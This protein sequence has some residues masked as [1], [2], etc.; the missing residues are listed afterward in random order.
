M[1]TLILTAWLALVA[2]ARAAEPLLTLTFDPVEN[3]ALVYTRSAALSGFFSPLNRL[4]FRVLV[5]NDDSVTLTI[6]G[7]RVAM[8]GLDTTIA[9][10]I[11]VAPNATKVVELATE[12]IFTLAE[13][14]PA[15]VTIGIYVA[16]NVTPKAAVLPLARYTPTVP[17][18]TYRLPVREGDLGPEQY[19]S[20][21]THMAPHVQRWGA[22][23]SVY[24]IDDDDSHTSLHPDTDGTE[25]AHSLG[26]GMPIR[27]MADGV[28]LRV[29]DG[30]IENPRPGKR[31]FQRL[32]EQD[33]A[34]IADAKV[35][36]LGKLGIPTQE[37]RTAVVTRTANGPFTITIWDS[38]SSGKTLLQRGS[39]TSAFDV[40]DIAVEALSVTR[41]VVAARLAGN[42]GTRILL[43]DVQED[44]A[45]QPVFVDDYDLPSNDV[46][47]SLARLSASRF[48]QSVRTA[49]GDLRVRVFRVVGD[50]I[51]YKSG[52]LAGAASSICT[53]PLWTSETSDEV[54]GGDYRFA[55]SLR[56][57]DGALKVIVWDWPTNSEFIMRRGEATAT[58][59]SRVAAVKSSGAKWITT[60]RT[61]PGGF[62]QIARW[63]ASAD[64]MTLTPELVT[65][66]EHTIENSALAA[67]HATGASSGTIHAVT[68]SIIAGNIELNGWGDHSDDGDTT[69][70]ADSESDAGVFAAT[71][72][73]I[74]QMDEMV[75]LLAAR[76]GAGALKLTTWT[77]AGGGGNFVIVRHGD[78]RVLYAHFL[79]GSVDES[80]L[81]AG[82][83]I[84]AGRFL[85][86]MG[87]SGSAGG[88][89]TH[90]HAD[91]IEDGHSD[92]DLIA[93]E[94]L[95]AYT[96]D[97]SIIPT[98]TARPIPFSDARSMRL[99]W[100]ERGGEGNT[101]NNFTTM[102]GHV[103]AEY[104]LGIRPELDTR[105]VH[106][107]LGLILPNGRKEPR[108]NGTGGPHSSLTSGIASVPAAGR[109][110]IRSGSFPGAR[111]L[112]APMTIRRYDFH[113][114][115]NTSGDDGATVV[116]GK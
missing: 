24:R 48:V 90:I 89:H 5:R 8:T 23:W 110:Y 55:T 33:G 12:D 47:L 16:E 71:T 95:F 14:A 86:R 43:Y 58:N 83:S 100:I 19:F 64:G 35:A 66:T 87:N 10:N 59:I 53:T 68:A 46:E 91:R 116:I 52:V 62:L 84:Q 61:S 76:T 3:G 81:Q 11:V 2:I 73:S 40:T 63:S 82:D 41:F 96:A 98:L 67:T 78:C 103:M 70:A 20:G 77:W 34:A 79:H 42:A 27:A 13:P 113:N 9:Q 28:V 94:Q 69:F 30:K 107:A 74:A 108:I 97:S 106:P 115:I 44:V 38:A 102:T 92:A 80:G 1:K 101:N 4:W 56:A 57:S 60:A 26:F 75:F 111:T 7:L 114:R 93:R 105:Y 49:E 45:G 25:N 15:S 39:L 104:S 112:S 99:L 65:T 37:R 32:V 51:Q 109:L 17:G 18:G 22:D 54:S 72:A 88:P 6:T 21:N 31:A 50:E 29:S 85:G 36:F